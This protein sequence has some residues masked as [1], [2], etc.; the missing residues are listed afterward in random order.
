MTSAILRTTRLCVDCVSSPLTSFQMA[1]TYSG[2]WPTD[3]R[4][5][6]DLGRPELNGNVSIWR[7]FTLLSSHSFVKSLSLSLSLSLT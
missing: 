2:E 6:V 5:C 7:R 1:T 3:W 4:H